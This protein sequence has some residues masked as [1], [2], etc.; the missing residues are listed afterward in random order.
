MKNLKYFSCSLLLAAVGV[1][2]FSGCSSSGS[3]STT[4]AS[5]GNANMATLVIKRSANM[6]TGLFLNVSVD[7]K[8]VGSA[9]QGQ[10]Y[11]GAL[12]PGAHV[13]SAVL[14]PNDMNLTP[15]KKKSLLKRDR[16]T[17]TLRFGMATP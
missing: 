5:T 2:I 1:L 14:D 10:T 7:G 8:R 17:P 11:R 15:A 13:V 4:A 16:P 9:S 3:S 6:G 12:S